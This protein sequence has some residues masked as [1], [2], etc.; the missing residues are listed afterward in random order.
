LVKVGEQFADAAW[1]LIDFTA[2]QSPTVGNTVTR[3][4]KTV[5]S[6]LFSLDVGDDLGHNRSNSQL[7]YFTTY[8]P[9]APIGS[10]FSLWGC[11][12][13]RAKGT[14]CFPVTDI[15]FPKIER[16]LGFF[17]LNEVGKTPVATYHNAPEPIGGS[18][19]TKGSAG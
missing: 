6:S 16:E 19:Y 12:M 13:I 4:V 5:E 11:E 8:I 17:K 7:D 9:R 15:Q 18:S 2:S 14:D 3:V 10:P 1:E